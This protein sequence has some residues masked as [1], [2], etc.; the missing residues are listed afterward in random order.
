MLAVMEILNPALSAS[1]ALSKNDLYSRKPAVTTLVTVLKTMFQKRK[2][3]NCFQYVIRVD[4]AWD[5]L[6]YR[7]VM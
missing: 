3:E 6:I 2:K 4:G 7:G 1:T 5:E